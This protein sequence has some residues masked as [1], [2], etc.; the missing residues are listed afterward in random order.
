MQ[1]SS[2]RP[3]SRA[4]GWR[5]RRLPGTREDFPGRRERRPL[6]GRADAR[7]GYP[8]VTTTRTELSAWSSRRYLAWAA[9]AALLITTAGV[10]ITVIALLQAAAAPADYRDSLLISVSYAVPYAVT[11][12]FLIVR[13]PDLPFGWLLAGAALLAAVGS[14]TAAL[15]YLAVSH[16]ASQRL[17][18][19]GYAM[20]ATAVLPL[21]VQG[22]VNVR[23]PSG[24][25][26]SRAGRVLEVALIAGIVLA[27][28]AGVLGDYKLR[29]VRPDSTVVQVANPLTGGTALGRYAA[30]LSVVVPLVV[31]LGLIAGLGVL[32][33]AWKATGIERYQLRWRA[34]GVVLSLLLFPLAVNQVLP[35]VIDVLDGLFFVTTLAIPVVRYRLWAI[36][37]VIRRSAAYALVTIAVVGGFAAIAAIGTAVASERVGFIVAAA[38]AAVTFAPARSYSQRLV[39]HFFYGQRSEPY[40]ALSDLGR[41]LAAVAAPGE[42]LPAVVAVV[43][44]SLRLPYV[45]IERPGDGSVLAASGEPAAAG[46]GRGGR[47]PL[48]YQG[49]TVGTLVAWPRRG[50]ETFDPRD[51]A[52]LADI[53]RQ[54]GAAVHAEALTADLLDSRQRLVSTREEERRRLR[55]DL[56]DGLGPLLT[57]IRLNL[58]AARAR[59]GHA[60]ARGDL[61]PLLGQAKDATTQAIADLR[62]I[63]YGLRPS[64]LD[65]LGLAGAIAAHIRRLTEGTA[66]QIT[67][68]AD[69]PPDLPAAVEVATFRIAVEAISNVVRHSGA[70]A[71]RVRLD[72]G[73]GGQLVVEVC[74]DGAGAGPWTAGVGMLAMRERAAEAG[75]T[76]TAG[77]TADGGTVRACFPLPARAAS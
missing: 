13:R 65:D 77:P 50:E 7:H 8:I 68:E 62:G 34:Y 39:D 10:V 20:A 21:A 66:V 72:A 3:R 36:D 19:L 5:S 28:A 40:R 69:P 45:A 27:L 73:S 71:C 9:A 42:V 18:F 15:V 76:L 55:R 35:T 12:G 47:W 70:R 38:G 33:R 54:A 75:A 37:T 56:H 30:G 25:L 31:L 6:R 52:V 48:S 22:L 46:D 41:R 4:Q 44:E 32:R 17:A 11:G 60:G 26:S 59:A 29:L 14:A 43:A 2:V 74:D 67:L 49:L 23:F 64:S 1:E 51:R 61:G 16:G 63:V 58:D 53:A 24:R 57:G